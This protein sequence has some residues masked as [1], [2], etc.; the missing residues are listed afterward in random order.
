LL[1]ATRGDRLRD[2]AAAASNFI[3]T[4]HSCAVDP[5]HHLTAHTTLTPPTPHAAHHA[6][7][8]SSYLPYSFT[9]SALNQL[10]PSAPFARS[11]Q[12]LKDGARDAGLT[13]A[14]LEKLESLEP[15][16]MSALPT[17]ETSAPPRDYER[18]MGATFI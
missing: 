12:L 17:A 5:P 16:A 9:C 3:C 18:R 4:S 6:C 8:T 1:R 10:P 7:S 2:S 15:A 13:D 11:L 14:W